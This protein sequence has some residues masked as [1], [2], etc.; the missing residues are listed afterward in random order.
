MKVF[1]PVNGAG[2][3]APAGAAG[4][5]QLGASTFQARLAASGNAPVS[6]QADASP[7]GADILLHAQNEMRGLLR[8]QY[9]LSMGRDSLTSNV[10][11]LRH[12]TAKNAISNIR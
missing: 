5:Q 3:P 6:P 7:T 9:Q 11:K 10:L 8:L 2:N 1:L 4:T 12:E